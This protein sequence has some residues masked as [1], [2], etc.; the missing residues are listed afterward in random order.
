MSGIIPSEEELV[1]ALRSLK[2]EHP[3]LGIAKTQTLLRDNHKDWSVSEKRIRKVLQSEGLHTPASTDNK[4][5][6]PSSQVNNTLDVSQFSKK[7]EVRFFDKAK[8]K[9]LVAKEDIAKDEVIWK[10]DPFVI[11]PEW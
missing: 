5:T 3:T 2:A 11:A 1:L 6:W 8:G 10:E 9:G 4:K 7:I